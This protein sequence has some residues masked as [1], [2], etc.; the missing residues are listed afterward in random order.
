MFCT[1]LSLFLLAAPV[2]QP[3]QKPGTFLF[4]P[5]T[6][7]RMA[8]EKQLP[9]N[10]KVMVIG[11]GKSFYPPSVNL[12]YE[13]YKGTL[14]EY[15]TMM[16]DVNRADGG[17]WKEIGSLKTDMGHASLSQVK[18][19]TEWGPVLYMHLVLLKDRMVY[20]LTAAALEEEFPQHYKQFFET[21]K[22]IRMTPTLMEQMTDS[23]LRNQLKERI[24]LI[25]GLL[26]HGTN[27][28]DKGF[29][30]KEWKEFLSWL[31]EHTSVMGSEWKNALL[32]K[33]EQDFT[34]IYQ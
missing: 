12:G 10:V 13:P 2:E 19:K 11:K 9:P 4:S 24:D 16:K 32:E 26:D 1:L 27:F 14:K 5:P 15:L 29:Q 7:W 3:V 31:N 33:L 34:T 6:G 23:S 17:E 20:V 21:M 30:E 18:M 8:D 28:Y 22:S 25:Y